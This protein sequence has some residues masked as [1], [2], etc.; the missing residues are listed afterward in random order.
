MF[1]LLIRFIPQII[2]LIHLA[3]ALNPHPGQGPSK[4][5]FVTTAL[6][7]IAQNVPAAEGQVDNLVNAAKPVVSTIVKTFNA[8]GWHPKVADAAAA[9]AASAPNQFVPFPGAVASS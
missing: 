1:D 4:L 9:F 7:Q 5:D 3:E 2:S 8:V 6:G